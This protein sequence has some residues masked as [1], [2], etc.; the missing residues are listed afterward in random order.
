MI[1]YPTNKGLSNVTRGRELQPLEV[2]NLRHGTTV[3]VEHR[4]MEEHGRPNNESKWKQTT[5]DP[6]KHGANDRGSR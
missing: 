1:Y 5:E 4:A 3:A 6:R 2:R